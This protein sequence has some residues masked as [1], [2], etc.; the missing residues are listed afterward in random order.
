[1]SSTK[2]KTAPRD[3]FH[4]AA[5]PYFALL[6]SKDTAVTLIPLVEKLLRCY[7]TTSNVAGKT[8]TTCAQVIFSSAAE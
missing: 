6:A 3:S 1:M 2:T 4:S 8:K 7:V 5:E